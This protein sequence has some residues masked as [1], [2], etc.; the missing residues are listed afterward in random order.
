MH[1]TSREDGRCWL[2]TGSGD[3]D[4]KVWEVRPGGGLSLIRE[5]SGLNGA[6]LSFGVRDSLL[7]A[8]LQAGEIIISDLETGACVRTIEV[9]EADVLTMSALGGDVFTAAADGRCLRVNEDFDCTAAFRAHQGIVL[10]SAIAR[11]EKGKWELMTAGNDSYI[12]V[13]L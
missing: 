3:C 13:S 1:V 9:H 2:M 10:S 7:Y 12:K 6:V 5:F 8:G 11:G 4:V